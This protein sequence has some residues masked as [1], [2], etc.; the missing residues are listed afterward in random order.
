MTTTSARSRRNSARGLLGLNTTK[1]NKGP[2]T[3]STPT[4][5]QNSSAPPIKARNG[6]GNH[7][8]KT[9]SPTKAAAAMEPSR[10]KN[11]GRMAWVKRRSSGR[12]DGIRTKTDQG[13]RFWIAHEKKS[14]EALFG[15][16]RR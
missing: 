16:Y 12:T 8:P 9:I 15:F 5:N 2:Q 10:W 13:E 11:A 3:T 14:A 4:I 7:Q 6:D 1:V